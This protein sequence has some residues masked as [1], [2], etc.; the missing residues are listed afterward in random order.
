MAQ[1][2]SK[3]TALWVVRRLREA[4]HQALLAGGCVRDMLLGEKST[5]YDVATDASPQQVRRL[6]PH[7][8]LVGAK[9]G[10]AMVIRDRQR[11]E[12]TTFRSDLSYSDGRRPDGVR[13]A[14]ARE[15]AL[16]R[17]FTINGMFY[18]PFAR[19]VIDYVGGQE[20]LK[21]GLVRTIGPPRDRFAEDYL[22]MIR[23]VRF[24]IRFGFR[25][26]PA[27]AQAARE[28][29]PKIVCISGERIHEELSKMLSRDS[30]EQALRLLHELG[31]SCQILPELCA[32]GGP[33]ETAALRVAEVARR[34]DA[35]LTFGALL[36]DLP[37]RT[38]SAIV[39]RWGASNELR[40]ALCFFAEHREDWQSA[41]DLPLAVFKRL[42]AR[43]DF[44]R[45]RALWAVRERLQTG[46]TALGRRIARRAAEIPA[47]KV[48]PSPLVSGADLKRLGLTEGPLLGR[49]VRELYD[50]QLNEQFHSR[51]EAMALARAKAQAAR[52]S[53]P[54]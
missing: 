31:L 20:D 30:A 18:D 4:G 49:I 54:P 15:D 27:T 52:Q 2:A 10:V 53:G 16:R 19:R 34:R 23:A 12:V 29:A 26:D 40:D 50:A 45:L 25:I 42:M 8:L 13:F 28:F 36:M 33:W 46:R 21:A 24:A 44:A 14:T 3:A 32:A 41:A 38:V 6:F 37:P 9:F 1:H 47:A 7:V 11:V 5:D 35:C 51:R 43:R 48:R 22:R 39:R 17:D